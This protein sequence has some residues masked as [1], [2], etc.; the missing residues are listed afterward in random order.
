MDLQQAAH[1]LER[2]VRC[3]ALPRA[4]EQSCGV[5][6]EE[7]GLAAL[8]RRGARLGQHETEVGQGASMALSGGTVARG[9]HIVQD[10]M[11]NGTR[12]MSCCVVEDEEQ[13][14]RVNESSMAFRG[15]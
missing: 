15:T 7:R 12:L 2:A 10:R 14:P 5:H 11:R 6:D 4:R 1:A 8:R 9:H 13:R 3:A